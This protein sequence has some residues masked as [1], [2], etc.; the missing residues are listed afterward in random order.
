MKKLLAFVAAAC[1]AMALSATTYNCHL[2]VVINGEATE[3]DEVP[4]VV[5]AHDGVYDLNLDNFV[6][7]MGDFPM[8][9]G[10]IALTGVEG[11]DQYGY[12]T[13]KFDDDLMITEGND[14]KS[15]L[16]RFL[17]SLPRPPRWRGMLTTTE[18]LALPM[19][20]P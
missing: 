6:L 2:K 17:V 19:W 20:A 12:T 15:L 1:C 16:S 18:R 7:W 11:V 9:V 14:P 10:N 8:P 3:Q 5:T 13:I 4:V